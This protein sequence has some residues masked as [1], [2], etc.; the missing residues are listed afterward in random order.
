[1]KITF[2]YI[3]N[4]I[5]EHSKQDL[6]QACYNILDDK[7]DEQKKP[8]WFVFLLM[9][10]TYLYGGEKYPS[11]PLTKNKLVKI[12]KSI[13]DFNEEHIS[14]FIKSGEIQRAFHILYSQQFYLQTYV[15]KNK[16]ATQLKLY[17]SL[18]SKYDINQS[19]IDKTGFTILDFI[20]IMQL[21]WL[22]INISELKKPGL[23]FN[24]YL[25]NDFLQI[26]S[27]IVEKEKVVKFL[28]LLVLDPVNPNEKIKQFKKGIRNEELQSLE[29]TFFTIYPLQYFNKKIKLIH[30]SVF[31]YTLNYFIY[32]YLKSNDDKFTTEFGL[33]FEK[34]IELGIKELNCEYIP[35]NEI[36]NLLPK[37]SNVVD[38]YLNESN[39]FIECKAIE[40]QA[41]PSVNPTDE[42]IYNSIKDSLIK[43][44]F[45]QLL[46][47]S[48]KLKGDEE[49]WGII[50]TYKKLYWSQ[51]TDLYDIGKSK[52]K[53]EID[54]N[55]LP[56]ENV[57]IIDIYTWDRII[58]IINDEK[59]SLLE[60]LKLAKK[61]N[62]ESKKQTFDMHLDDFEN[63][64]LNL[65][66]LSSEIEQLDLKEG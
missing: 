35:E 66:Y 26:V 57:F 33:R 15:D 43:A 30:K 31:N 20:K 25:E 7:K 42:L 34:Y 44:Y 48:K 53:Q 27:T 54:N 65:S 32:D 19:F 51:F 60:I 62:A 52:Q 22:Y 61:N 41:Y 63:N 55:H 3:R 14:D 37:N 38:F 8:I 6:L 50:L 58:N 10:W 5:R 39:I 46:S 16:F 59:T 64:S 13:T 18:K 45:K 40:L 29:K 4:R 36:K 9:K 28:K 24:G 21:T 2:S 12:L 49:N 11:K 17:N 56:P 1:M 23:Y 47:V